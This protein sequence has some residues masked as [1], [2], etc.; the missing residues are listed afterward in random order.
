MVEEVESSMEAQFQFIEFG[1]HV[2]A[3]ED[4]V[5]RRAVGCHQERA[6]LIST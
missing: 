3:V 6:F 1:L 5:I 4:D 2:P